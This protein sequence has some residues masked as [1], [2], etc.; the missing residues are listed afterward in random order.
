MSPALT[1]FYRS[2]ATRVV[3][4]AS[5]ISSRS[6]T[7]HIETS[8]RAQKAGE[9]QQLKHVV[10][11]PPCNQSNYKLS[12]MEYR[13]FLQGGSSFTLDKLYAA[14]SKVKDDDVVNVQFT[15]GTTGLPK[16]AL[17]TH[18]YVSLFSSR[19]SSHIYQEIFSITAASSARE[20]T[21][22]PPTSYAVR[23]LSSIAS[24]S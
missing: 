11:L 15:S 16:A 14:E 20:C 8:Q 1:D 6:M 22:L 2:S 18:R 10:V 13:D 19:S 17:L 4:I 24:A 9:L 12:T 21:S 23:H 3:L 7:S 5:N